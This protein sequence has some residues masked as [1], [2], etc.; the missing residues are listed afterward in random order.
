MFNM[1]LPLMVM[2]KACMIK[3]RCIQALLRA[4]GGQVEK[5]KARDVEVG[6]WLEGGT[7]INTT[8]K[9]S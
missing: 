1:S 9:Q 8:R 2:Y 7:E 5:D 6:M 3:L 4:P